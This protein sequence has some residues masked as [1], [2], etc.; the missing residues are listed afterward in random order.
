[1][2][3]NAVISQIVPLV[4]NIVWLVLGL[5]VV[6][7]VGYYL[8]VIKRRKSWK[9]NIWELKRV[10]DKLSVHRVDKDLLVARKFNKNK[11]TAYIFKKFRVETL[12]PSTE[13]ID[14]VGNKQEANYLR[15][16]DDYVPF[17]KEIGLPDE[18]FQYATDKV[19]GEK[20]N[21]FLKNLKEKIKGINKMSSAEVESRYVYAPL[22]KNLSGELQ[23]KPLDYDV[24]MMRINAI[25]NREKIYKD[26]ESWMQKYG[27]FVAIGMIV[28]LIIV[29][30]Y[31]SYDYSSGVIKQAFGAADKVSGPLQDLVTRLSGN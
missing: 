15:L 27:T 23:F 12:P 24:N 26:K 13:C 22:D 31:F 2:E 8:F 7:A 29:V 4:M 3:V 18:F 30:L 21:V 14:I 28:V 19:T 5:G 9:C 10:G 1:M 11:Q 20:K 17:T 6:V 25:D 16:L